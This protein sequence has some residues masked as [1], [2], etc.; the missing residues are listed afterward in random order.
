VTDPKNT[1]TITGII[2]NGNG[3]QTNY[4]PQRWGDYSMMAVDPVDDCTFWYTNQYYSSPAN[5][6]KLLWQSRIGHFKLSDL[7]N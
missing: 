5:G 3:S 6:Q 4:P 2:Q 7:C 1:L